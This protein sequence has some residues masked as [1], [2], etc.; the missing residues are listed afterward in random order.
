MN[1]IFYV[2]LTLTA[3]YVVFHTAEVFG[4]W[5]GVILVVPV[6]IWNLIKKVFGK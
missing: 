4:W 6:K 1:I 2:F 3:I 5:Y